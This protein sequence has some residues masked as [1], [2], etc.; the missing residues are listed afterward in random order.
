MIWLNLGIEWIAFELQVELAG[1]QFLRRGMRDT[2][3]QDDVYRVD[4]RLILTVRQSVLDPG[5]ESC[6]SLSMEYC[7]G[8]FFNSERS[9]A[10]LFRGDSLLS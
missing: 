10:C 1:N 5:L 9:V 3:R 7:F 8:Q 4:K 6:I 2:S